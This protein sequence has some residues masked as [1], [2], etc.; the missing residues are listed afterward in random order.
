MTPEERFKH[1]EEMLAEAAAI[2]RDQARVLAMHSK[3][4]VEHDERMQR[5]DEANERI[6]RHLEV[7]IEIMD[8]LIRK[9]PRSEGE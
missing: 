6:Q 4:L 3:M 5:M 8:G 1:I 7:L 9:P 2:Q